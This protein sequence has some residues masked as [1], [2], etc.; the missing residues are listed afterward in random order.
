MLGIL[1]RA[2]HRVARHA[3]Y[4][5]QESRIE[6]DDKIAVTARADRREGGLCL[7]GSPKEPVVLSD[8]TKVPRISLPR[9][10]LR[11]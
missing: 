10:Q 9:A 6:P 11:S 4:V 7:A 3:I 5:L 8:D 1:R 2:N